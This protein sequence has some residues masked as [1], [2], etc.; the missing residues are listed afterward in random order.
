[1]LGNFSYFLSTAEFKKK[2]SF[3]NTIRMSNSL[4]PGQAQ[5][6]VG[7]DLGA[8]YLQRLSADD[9]S[10]QRVKAGMVFGKVNNEGLVI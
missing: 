4:D 1:M 9:T 3:R 2:K 10:G 5:H 6:F 7:P 8:T